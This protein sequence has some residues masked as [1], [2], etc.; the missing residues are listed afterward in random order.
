MN[1]EIPYKQTA[2]YLY[3]TMSQSSSVVL[4]Y[5]RE[6]GADNDFI[7]RIY[8]EEDGYS[9]DVKEKDSR[10][11]SHTQHFF[12]DLDQVLNYVSLLTYQVLNDEDAQ[13]PFTYLQYSIPFFPSVVLPIKNLR[14]SAV[15]ERLEQA[16]DFYFRD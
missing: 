2:L 10:D 4:F 7:V 14:K 13:N 3:R 5:Q 11:P 15:Y 8:R 6:S 9:I 16:L 1:K 12:E